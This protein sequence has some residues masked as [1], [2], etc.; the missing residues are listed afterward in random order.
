MPC[1]W[2]GAK[3]RLLRIS[4]S[5]VPCSKAMR[6]SVLSRVDILPKY[7][8]A[9]VECQHETGL[10]LFKRKIA[11]ALSEGSMYWDLSC[12]SMRGVAGNYCY[13]IG[14]VSPVDIRCSSRISKHLPTYRDRSHPASESTARSEGS[15]LSIESQK[16]LLISGLDADGSVN[17]GTVVE[18]SILHH[19]AAAANVADM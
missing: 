16:C 14:L 8:H 1:P 13:R 10:W 6:S 4:R 7:P 5:R 15:D 19:E 2:H 3:T 11:D 12:H 17:R 18:N 9:W